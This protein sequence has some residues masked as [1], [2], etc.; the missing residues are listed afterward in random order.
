MH[1]GLDLT[2]S[3]CPISIYGNPVALLKF[4]KT[5]KIIL[6]MSSGSKKK[7]TR[8]TCLSETKASHLQRMWAEVSFSAPHLLHSVLSDSPSR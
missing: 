3:L 7:D 2:G 8:Y 4:Q 5:P 1:L 6:L